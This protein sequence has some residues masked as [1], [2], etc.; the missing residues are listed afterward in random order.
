MEIINLLELLNNV[1][2]LHTLEY[3]SCNCR[4][5]NFF[6]FLIEDE[7]FTQRFDLG[8]IYL[9]QKNLEYHVIVDG[10]NRFLSLSLLLHAVCECYKKTTPRNEEAIKTIRSKYLLNG[11]RTKL[12]LNDSDQAIYDKIIFGEKLSGK[13][14]ETPMFQ[15]LHM[16]WS[17]IKQDKLQA[18]YIFKMLNKIFVTLVNT[19]NVPK[20]DLYYSLNKDKREINQLALIENYLSSIG[21]SKEWEKIKKIYNNKSADINM[22]FEDFFVTKFNY[23]K[24][25]QNKLYELFYNYFETMLQYM[26]E[27]TLIN[28]IG[29]SAI[30]YNKILNVDVESDILKQ[31]LVQIKMHKGED[32]Y[33]YILN[34]FE[35][36]VDSN[37]TEAT[38]LEILQTIDE[39][40]KSRLKNPSGV[41]FNELISYL[42]AFITCK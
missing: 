31:V 40:L 33:A 5:L 39:Y 21:I 34:I 18:A 20:R 11:F 17:Q 25:N 23:K 32:T 9:N 22:F 42:N 1:N 10:L 15:L 2:E 36:Y 27:D 30:L 41:T 19:D 4:L 7:Q 26:P 38:F 14:K 35:D 12:R 28:K 37:I 13:E 29:R 8:L 6:D 3:A 16:L 24:Y